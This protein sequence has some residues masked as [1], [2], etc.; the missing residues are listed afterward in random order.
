MKTTFFR[1]WLQTK[2]L[3]IKIAT[4]LALIKTAAGEIE[5]TESG[6]KIK[7]E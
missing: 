2:K 3:I 5:V 6:D 7:Y 4:S 1:G